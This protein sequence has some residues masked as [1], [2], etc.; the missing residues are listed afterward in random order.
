MDGIAYLLLLLEVVEELGEESL[1]LGG[2]GLGG[3]REREGRGFGRG[4]RW[5]AG[6]EEIVLMREGT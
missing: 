2:L 1:L 3:L 4:S 6:N 5:V